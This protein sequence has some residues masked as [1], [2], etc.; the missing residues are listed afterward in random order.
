MTTT[1]NMPTQ[2]TP[3]IFAKFMQTV[4]QFTLDESKGMAENDFIVKSI[5]TLFGEDEDLSLMQECLGNILINTKNVYNYIKYQYILKKLLIFA[6]LYINK[7]KECVGKFQMANALTLVITLTKKNNTTSQEDAELNELNYRRCILIQKLFEYVV[8]L[9]KK[10]V[11]DGD[12]IDLVKDVVI[13]Y[14]KDELNPDK[15][16]ISTIIQPLEPAK[17]ERSSAKT[18]R[19]ISPYQAYLAKDD[20][21]LKNDIHPIYDKNDEIKEYMI[22][23]I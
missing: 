17:L 3:K 12:N 7:H 22:P 23:V 6:A 5:P 16:N 19:R 4:F 11:D 1:T 9:S 13:Y 18:Y 8:D 2:F 10:I 14:E 15:Y 21:K 20:D